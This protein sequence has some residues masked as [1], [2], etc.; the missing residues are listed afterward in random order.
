MQ[1]SRTLD[2]V[3]GVFSPRTKRLRQRE[4][5]LS[6]VMHE[7]HKRGFDAAG[8]RGRGS[9]WKPIAADAN[10]ENR[11][12]MDIIRDR[13]RDLYIN[14]PWAKNGVDILVNNTIGR[15]IVA[16]TS[17]KTLAPIWKKWSTTTDC[18]FNGELSL[19]GLQRL[20]ARTT[21]VTGECL[22]RK[23]MRK[24][25]PGNPVPL[26]LQV[27][28]PDLIDTS[29]DELVMHSGKKNG[30]RVVQGIQFGRDGRVS[31]LYLFDEH[32]SAYNTASIESRFV[33]IDKIIH[34]HDFRRPNEVR[35]ASRLAPIVHRLRNIDLYEDAELEKQHVAAMFA[36]FYKNV[37]CDDMKAVGD[38]TVPTHMEAGTIEMLPD[39]Y[40]VQFSNPPSKE[41]YS[42]YMRQQLL[43]ISAALG[44]TYEALT[45][46]LRQTSFSSARIGQHEMTRHIESI[47]QDIFIPQALSRV[48]KWFTEAAS[49][50]QGVRNAAHAQATWHIP[51]RFIVDPKAET[52]ADKEAV[53][54]GFKSLQGVQRSRGEDPELLIEE[55]EE[56]NIAI[57]EKGLVLDTDP[58]KTDMNGSA[59]KDAEVKQ[60]ASLNG[61]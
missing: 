59:R 44:I 56:M 7:N 20:I 49:L 14:N 34:V 11:N 54:A 22:I 55:L 41:G 27:L 23:V 28:E 19:S 52:Q 42:E 1:L 46:D 45:S 18:D 9:T 37:E 13:V 24:P 40:D 35:A 38:M 47:Q 31:G 30:S 2:N 5:M 57:D 8:M 58:R 33:S 51:A 50:M 26:Q 36:A 3:I 21:F 32:P 60:E 43:S 15:G 6:D 10:S 17:D 61:D 16:R 12:S 29:K 39:G 48:W 53:R 4:R 25:T